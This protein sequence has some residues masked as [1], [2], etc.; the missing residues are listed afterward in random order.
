MLVLLTSL[1]TVAAALGAKP[2]LF[3]AN[4]ARSQVMSPA[5]LWDIAV[6]SVI[7]LVTIAFWA[8]TLLSRVQ[9]VRVRA[10]RRR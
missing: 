2:M 3:A 10:R 6:M 8:V 9:R 5:D 4:V 1:L 7:F